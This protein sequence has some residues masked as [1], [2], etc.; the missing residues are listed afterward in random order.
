MS[1]TLR[2]LSALLDYP[3]DALRAGIPAL[4]AAIESEAL[5]DEGQVAALQPLFRQLA[6]A[7]LLALQE[8]Y[9]EIFDR[10]RQHS[11]CLFEHVHGEARDRGQAM[12]DLRN[13]YVAAGL[14]LIG[15]ELPD[16]LPLFLEYCSTLAPRE[17]I[18]ELTETGAIL[19]LLAGRL[20]RAG[21]PYAGVFT[22]LCQLAGI[23][24]AATAG[25]A[26]ADQEEPDLDE[27]WAE[28]EVRF[29]G[30]APDWT[31]PP[32]SCPR[33]QSAVERF[34]RPEPANTA[35]TPS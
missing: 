6:D 19:A 15:H 5:L 1:H 25:S 9:V 10:S 12:V 22:L 28:D 16:Y 20:T 34:H 2:V 18:A 33:A 21:T 13:R 32:A 27:A 26:P 7:D 29:G 30:S 8:H 35:G 11:L 3:G 31:S 24:P 23:A 14:D 17:G 4:A